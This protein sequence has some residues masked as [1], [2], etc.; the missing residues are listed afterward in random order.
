[1]SDGLR[2]F[3]TAVTGWL[4]AAGVPY[5]VASRL[6][7]GSERQLADV[8]GI[9]EALGDDLDSSTSRSG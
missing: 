2:R 3:L 6:S 4:D 7:G 9:L 8:A 1:L 5:M